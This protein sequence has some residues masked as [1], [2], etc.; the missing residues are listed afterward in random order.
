MMSLMHIPPEGL[1]PLH[2]TPAFDPVERPAHYANAEI[3]CIDVIREAL[4][5]ETDPF[6]GFCRGNAMKYVWRAGKKADKAEDLKK[7]AWYVRTA[8]EHLKRTRGEG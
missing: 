7:A 4:K 2:P 5:E 1:R 6:V 8:A 3:E